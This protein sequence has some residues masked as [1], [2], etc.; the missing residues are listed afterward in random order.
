MLVPGHFAGAVFDLKMSSISRISRDIASEMEQ[1]AETI[2]SMSKN[3][4]HP[5]LAWQNCRQ[6]DVHAISVYIIAVV[7]FLQHDKY[8]W[9]CCK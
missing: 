7:S 2:S 8:R 6:A 9:Y 5:C 1:R 3:S 4:H